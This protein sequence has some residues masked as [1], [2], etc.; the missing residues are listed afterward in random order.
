MAITGLCFWLLLG[1]M[2]ISH[3][4]CLSPS[5]I[6]ISYCITYVI[7]SYL[8]NLKNISDLQ[9]S[10]YVGKFEFNLRQLDLF[11]KKYFPYIIHSYVGTLIN[12]SSNYN[13]LIM[14][15]LFTFICFVFRTYNMPMSNQNGLD[16]RYL[17]F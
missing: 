13:R 15:E 7:Y 6:R 16:C 10:P 9:I 2:P 11:W 3:N 12:H 17:P 8:I 1:P 5:P 14:L 4:V